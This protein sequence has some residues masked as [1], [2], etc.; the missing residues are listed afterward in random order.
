LIHKVRQEGKMRILT[1]ILVGLFLAAGCVTTGASSGITYDVRGSVQGEVYVSPGGTFRV[2][3]PEPVQPGA[4]VRDTTPA[5]DV[6]LVT[7]TDYLCREFDISERPGQLRNQSLEEWAEQN[8]FPKLTRP[9]ISLI[10][11]KTVQT[12]YGPGLSVRYRHSHQ[13]PCLK[14]ASHDGKITIYQPPRLWD[15][16]EGAEPNFLVSRPDAEVGM[17]ILYRN[18]TFY[19][20]IYVLGED[21]PEFLELKRGP[22]E[23][24]LS[25][26]LNDFEIL[27][28][29]PK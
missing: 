3:I 2:R 1:P 19:R 13:S 4:L 25:R 21:G 7:F 9:E 27:R 29:P 11:H 22:L 20:L 16:V 24:V 8:L 15:T 14:A 12:K 26:F 6:L 17:Y 5:P 23:H 18:G 10:E 28:A